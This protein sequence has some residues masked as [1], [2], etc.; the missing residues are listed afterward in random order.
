[1]A[2]WPS[3]GPPEVPE[4][5]PSTSAERTRI[6][7][8]VAAFVR[9]SV[10]RFIAIAAGAYWLYSERANIIS[11]NDQP[12][13]LEELQDAASSAKEGYHRHHIV[14]QTSAEQDGFPRSQIDD[15]ENLVRV[16]TYKHRAISDWYSK[17]NDGFGG[18]TPRD[19]LRGRSWEER[20][21]VGL[22]AL[23]KFGVLKP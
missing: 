7:R 12:K 3:N 20:R 13:T 6:T 8:L 23:R 9:G 10:G 14:E 22:A 16:P 4:K 19:Y 15:R 21:E 5:R 18:Q 17:K 1:V 11:Q 2:P